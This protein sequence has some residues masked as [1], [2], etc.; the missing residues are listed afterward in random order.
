MKQGRGNLFLFGFGLAAI[1]SVSGLLIYIIAPR[2][3]PNPVFGVRTGYSFANRG[4]WNRVN[5]VGGLLLIILGFLLYFLSVTQVWLDV[6]KQ[7]G[8]LNIAAVLVFG[9]LSL[10]IWL[11]LYSKKLA[12]QEMEDVEQGEI[13]I[14]RQPLVELLTLQITLAIAANLAIFFSEVNIRTSFNLPTLTNSPSFIEESIA[15]NIFQFSFSVLGFCL[16]KFLVLKPLTNN[17]RGASLALKIAQLLVL[18]GV[19]ASL[20]LL[21][22]TLAELINNKIIMFLRI[23]ILCIAGLLIILR[24]ESSTKPY[25]I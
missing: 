12:G 21:S 7:K 11:F 25:S 2:V 9:L 1:I 24:K 23:G 5:R 3:G 15:L 6:S 8:I 20:Y 14:F 19:V 16:A 17:A 13:K 18:C 22:I 10:V 4:V